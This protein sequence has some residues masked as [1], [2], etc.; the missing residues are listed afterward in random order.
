MASQP[1]FD[2]I[3]KVSDL[4][5]SLSRLHD[6][7]RSQDKHI[8]QCLKNERETASLLLKLQRDHSDLV[9]Y[10]SS[11][12]EYCLELD[13]KS[14]KKHIILT[15]IEES[16]AERGE[17]DIEGAENNEMETEE[18]NFDPTHAVAY[19]TLQT[20]F[21]T[22]VYEDIDI[23]YRIG[24]K[25][26]SP[27][28]ILIKFSKENIRNEVNKRRTNLKDSEM[29]Q[30]SY[31]NDDLPVKVNQRRSDMRCIVNHAKSK[32]VNAR[33]LGDRIS[34]DNKIYSYKDIDRLPDG[35]KIADAKMIA[36][37]KGIAFQSNYAFLSN[38]YPAPLKYKGMY[39]ATSEHAYQFTRATFLGKHDAA[40]S[41]RTAKTPQEAKRA[42]ARVL[43][44]K[45][46]DSCKY[47][48]MKEIVYAKFSQNPTLQPQLTA[49]GDNPLLEASY[50]S[51]WGCGLPL[52]SKK[53]IHG[54]WQGMNCLGA[55][56]A[57]CRADIRKEKAAG[58]LHQ[59]NL[60]SSNNPQ[61]P[62]QQSKPTQPPT[63]SPQAIPRPLAQPQQNASYHRQSQPNTMKSPRHNNYQRPDKHRSDYVQSLPVSQSLS[64]H[65][66]NWNN[67]NQAPGQNL[68]GANN[69][70][71]MPAWAN[72]MLMQ[73][74][75][76]SFSNPAPPPFYMYPQMPMMTGQGFQFPPPVPVANQPPPGTQPVS[77]SN[78]NNLQPFFSQTSPYSSG[79]DFNQGERRLSFDPLMSPE[80]RV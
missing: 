32:N 40:F 57:E 13:V 7:V 47:K 23:A 60:N 39:F 12:E 77:P 67:Q 22:L 15:N 18:S 78:I 58:S 25:G 45:E 41:A 8:S 30:S 28:P 27:R 44:T 9:K 1:G 35:L 26:P 10:A 5:K 48:I 31:L 54:E 20:I 68:Q 63:L 43:S 36:T 70:Y 16:P 11:L 52:T 64:Q 24:K 79:S 56:L 34:V 6:H 75:T 49:T 51:Y 14:R 53:M 33:I 71:P 74:P 66:A 19:S 42:C 73:Q 62:V 55:I 38:F 37:P 2:L 21:E 59:S 76:Y 65:G 80:I 50:D 46:W 61:Q 29:T 69:N 4:E 72:P 17:G 3:Q